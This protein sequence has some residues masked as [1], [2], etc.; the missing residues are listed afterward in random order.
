MPS[1]RDPFTTVHKKDIKNKEG[2]VV[3]QV[4]Y[5]GWSQVA[6]RLDDVDPSWSFE[7]V[8]LGPD[9]CLGSLKIGDRTFQ[10]IGYAENAEMA[11]KKEPLKDAVSDAFKR[12]AALAGVARYLYDKDTDH[13]APASRNGSQPRQNGPQRA[14]TPVAAPASAPANDEPPWAAPDEG[15]PAHLQVVTNPAPV[16]P[17]E[18]QTDRP[19]DI[20]DGFYGATCP[21]HKGRAWKDTK[22]GPKCTA[23]TD[24]EWCRWKPSRKWIAEHEMDAVPA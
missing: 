2:R 21:V 20:R 14:P 18:V 13:S 10:N 5:V 8:N 4:D 24:G 12:C 7:V 3:A 22:Y 17:T 23:Q 6:D 15:L 1:L 16:A 19:L 11:W 9:W